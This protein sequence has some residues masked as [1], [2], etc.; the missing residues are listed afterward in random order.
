MEIGKNATEIKCG[1]MKMTAAPLHLYFR[2]VNKIDMYTETERMTELFVLLAYT[3]FPIQQAS[4]PIAGVEFF[5]TS[6]CIFFFF[7]SNFIAAFDFVY[8]N[9]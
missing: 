2:A 7:C 1:I 8:K 9:L 6:F 3:L 4:E 5:N